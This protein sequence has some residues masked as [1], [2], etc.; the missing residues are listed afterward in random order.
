MEALEKHLDAK[1]VALEGKII[2]WIVG[3]AIVL[4]S[5]LIAILLKLP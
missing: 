4:F 2:K 5:A 3:L 1:L